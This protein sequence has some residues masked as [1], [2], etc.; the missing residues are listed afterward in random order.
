MHHRGH[1]TDSHLYHFLV[2]HDH[3][4]LQ[5]EYNHSFFGSTHAIMLLVVPP[6]SW[7]VVINSSWLNFRNIFSKHADNNEPVYSDLHH[8]VLSCLLQGESID[9]HLNLPMLSLS[10]P[11]AHD[12][13][14]FLFGMQ[15]FYPSLFLRKESV[16][17]QEYDG[18]LG[19][20]SG[21][22]AKCLQAIHPHILYSQY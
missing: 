6:F 4:Q 14:D 15:R 21:E 3:A 8:R 12:E 19:N 2:L 9:S 10:F 7:P 17:L 13:E 18:H 20:H 22:E 1:K 11:H 5:Y 16:I